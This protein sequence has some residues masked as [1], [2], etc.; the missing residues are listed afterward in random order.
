M[1]ALI[2]VGKVALVLF[3]FW[4]VLFGVTYLRVWHRERKMRAPSRAD[5]ERQYN[6]D[7]PI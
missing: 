4:V 3:L 5:I 7:L 2:F 6:P 1:Q